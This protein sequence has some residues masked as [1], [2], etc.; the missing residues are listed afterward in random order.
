MGN[1]PEYLRTKTRS[2]LPYIAIAGVLSLVLGL[3]IPMVFY[4][5]GQSEVPYW[6][7]GGA[8]GTLP[9]VLLCVLAAAIA[10]GRVNAMRVKAGHRVL[11]GAES[12]YVPLSPR[13]APVDTSRIYIDPKW[14]KEKQAEVRAAIARVPGTNLRG[15]AVPM[16][17]RWLGGESYDDDRFVISSRDAIIIEIGTGKTVE[18]GK[19]VDY[20]CDLWPVDHALLM[21]ELVQELTDRTRGEWVYGKTKTL[22]TMNVRD[23]WRKFFRKSQYVRDEVLESVGMDGKHGI[24]ERVLADFKARGVDL[25]AVK[26]DRFAT[27]MGELRGWL[28]QN[29]LD[30]EPA[31]R[32]SAD[33][34]YAPMYWGLVPRYIEME[35]RALKAESEAANYR[36]AFLGQ[37]ERRVKVYGGAY[38]RTRSPVPEVASDMSRVPGLGQ[39]EE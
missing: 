20:I 27:F 34:I 5:Q 6:E 32:G 11:Q 14:P 1:E 21:P 17:Y 15:E 19:S 16:G 7:Q 29:R 8:L 23:E 2:W 38:A 28:G 3:L 12:G 25:G 4:P 37:S 24:A 9:V 10:V 39:L 31:L 26:G 33:G 13:F 22:I 35:K 18:S 36:D 30:P